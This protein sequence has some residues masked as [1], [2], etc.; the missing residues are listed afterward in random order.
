[1]T[2]NFRRFEILLPLRF[3]G[4]RPVPGELI[5]E[6]LIELE[7]QFGAV[8]SETQTI[9]GQWRHQGGTFRDDLTRVFVDA[10]DTVTSVEFFRR[11]KETLKARFQQIDIWMT[12]YPIEV[13]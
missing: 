11:V 9:Q 8:S 13:I 6:T 1:M 4:G 7:Q 12:T 2:S 10:P 3:N 5:A